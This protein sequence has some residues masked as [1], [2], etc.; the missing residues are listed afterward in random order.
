MT[1]EDPE[2]RLAE[3]FA[4]LAR[5]LAVEHANPQATYNRICVVAVQ[6]ID[7][8]ETAGMSLLQGR[9]VGSIARTDPVPA[10]IDQIQNETQQGPCVDAIRHQEVFSTGNLLEDERWPDFSARARETGVRSIVS[11]RLFVEQDTMG[12]L[13]LYSRQIDAFDD[14]DQ[15]I[16]AVFAAHAAVAM[17]SARREEQLQ[18]KADTRDVIGRA[19]GMLMARSHL[20]EEQAFDV[21]RRASQRLNVKLRDVAEQLARGEALSGTGGDEVTPPPI[22]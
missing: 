9:H 8:C 13:N 7:G 18:R 4:D 17:S 19:K 11:F 22:P 20:T 6:T 10:E 3:V 14:H 5:S 1:A 2:I 12:A 21:L 16:G 15:A